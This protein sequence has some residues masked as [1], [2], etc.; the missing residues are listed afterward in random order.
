MHVAEANRVILLGALRIRRANSVLFDAFARLDFSPQAY[1]L[2]WREC[3]MKPHETPLT[4]HM[5]SEYKLARTGIRQHPIPNLIPM[6]P[7]YQREHVSQLSRE[8]Q[9]ELATTA[10]ICAARYS[11][12]RMGISRHHNCD[13]INRCEGPLQEYQRVYVRYVNT[14]LKTKGPTKWEEIRKK[15]ALPLQ[16]PEAHDATLYKDLI[17][18]SDDEGDFDFDDSSDPQLVKDQL[19][20]LWNPTPA[21]KPR[22]PKTKSS[23]TTPGTP[24][25][26]M[27]KK[28]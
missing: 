22:A 15:H 17:V 4:K 24:A 25:S 28:A 5:N 3:F 16:L 13:F 23:H 7:K 8:Q 19:Q 27:Q 11:L 12:N 21:P 1:R 14:V 26:K 2:S 6:I 18:V 10:V 20:T 9:I